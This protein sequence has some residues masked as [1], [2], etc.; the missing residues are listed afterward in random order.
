MKQSTIRKLTIRK[1]LIFSFAVNC[2]AGAAAIRSIYIRGGL[3]YL[4]TRLHGD[5]EHGIGP[6]AANYI[7]RQTEFERLPKS[8]HRVVFLGDSLTQG[9]EW[10]EFYPGALNR[11]IGGDTSAGLLKRLDTVTELKP[12]AVF[13]MIGSNDL[14]NIH[15]RPEQTVAN[16]RKAVADIRRSSPETT[17]YLESDLPTWSVQENIYLRTVNRGLR[18]LADGKTVI[19]VDLYPAFLSGEVLNPSFTS[20]GGHLNGAGYLVWKHLI[21]PYVQP[22]DEAQGSSALVYPSSTQSLNCRRI[23]CIYSAAIGMATR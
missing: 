22:F 23:S 10:G 4:R 19:Y 2:I 12:K 9:C 15:L 5:P 16:I 14:L 11:G 21:D 8:L 3:E 18:L 1:L 7:H 17:I 13:L 6:D 20:D